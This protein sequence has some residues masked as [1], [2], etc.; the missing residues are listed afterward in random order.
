MSN[1]NKVCKFDQYPTKILLFI[2]QKMDRIAQRW[3]FSETEVEIFTTFLYS[4]V[5]VS[6]PPYHDC[7][8]EEGTCKTNFGRL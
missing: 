5:S 3:F 1:Y 8:Q 2:S 6:P 7:Y 4:I